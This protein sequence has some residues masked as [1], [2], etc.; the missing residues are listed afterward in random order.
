M[1]IGKLASVALILNRLSRYFRF[2]RHGEDLAARLG[3]SSLTFRVDP[4][5][6]LIVFAVRT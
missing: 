4:R 6:I 2:L 3:I 1:R 5:D